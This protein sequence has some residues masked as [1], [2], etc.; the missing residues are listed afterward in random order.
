MKDAILTYF[1]GEKHGGLAAAAV[2]F[3][4]LV[5]AG[6]LSTP[7]AGAEL[8]PFAV[9][10]AVLGLL[11]LAVGIGLFAKTGPQI[12]ELLARLE[13]E[14]AAFYAAEGA[15]MAKVQKNFVTLEVVWCVVLAGGS[16]A[17]VLAK[18]SPTP[19]GIAA[20]LVLTA[21]FFLT[22]DL[23]AERRGAIYY[24]ALR[25]PSTKAPVIKRNPHDP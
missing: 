23:V 9:A 10:L 16:I 18:R 14:P 2:G 5:A 20:A 24:A 11:E 15:R 1:Q 8:R 22:F 7:R 3:V 6:L 25:E 13:S 17:A 19:S 12:A 21:G 4:S